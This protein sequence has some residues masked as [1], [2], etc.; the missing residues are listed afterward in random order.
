MNPTL[1]QIWN[2]L[3]A[4]LR[5]FIR[6]RVSDAAEAEDILQDVFL[7]LA[8]RADELPE[9]A[10]LQGWVFLIARN[11]VID[12]YRTRKE[13][14]A[15]PETLESDAAVAPEEL[16][17]LKT[18]FRRMIHSLPGQYREAIL[19]TEIEGLS[20]VDL[21][22]R[23]GISVSGAKSRVQRGRQQLKEML[24]ECCEFEFDRRGR[25]FD[26]TPRGTDCPECSA[27]KSAPARAA[28][29]AG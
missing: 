1:E 19:L 13:T 29:G 18:S 5:E 6:R 16:E 3:A 12:H 15:V 4:K 27:P 20:Q 14:V 26:C 8:K 17:G 7:K 22:K 23:L 21:A 25:V 9:P 11:A 10:K 2:E 24:L 28:R